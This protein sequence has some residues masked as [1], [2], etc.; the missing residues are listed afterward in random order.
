MGAIIYFMSYNLSS[1]S[2][3]PVKKLT[4]GGCTDLFNRSTARIN[5]IDLHRSAT[6][7]GLIIPG[8][9][10]LT[11]STLVLLRKAVTDWP[12]AADGSEFLAPTFFHINRLDVL[13][14]SWISG[15]LV[16]APAN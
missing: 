13:L 4:G 6:S 12:V 15:R 11:S 1:K 16:W 7:I 10:G 3:I 8:S 14:G 5:L 2:V 9:D